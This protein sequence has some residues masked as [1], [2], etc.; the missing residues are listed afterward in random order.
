MS[1]DRAAQLSCGAYAA[2]LIGQRVRRLVSLQADVLADR[3]PEPLHQMRVCCRQLR[4]TLEQFDAALL[5][6]EQVTPRRVAKVGHQ[7]GLTRDLDVLRERIEQQ[8]LPGLPAGELQLLQRFFKAL[9]RERRHAF[10]A[11]E[12]TIKGRRYLK[13]LSRLQ[14]WLRQPQFTPMGVQPVIDWL[15]DLA[16]VAVQELTL[17][18]GWHV[19]DLEAA[20]AAEALHEL[21]RRIKRARYG[22]RNLCDLES[23]FQPWCDQFKRMQG[24]LGD[25]NDLQLLEQALDHHL[26][27]DLDTQLPVLRSRLLECRQQAWQRWQVAAAELK[28]PAGRRQLQQLLS[29]LLTNP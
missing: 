17:Q 7:L 19:D 22:L 9:R 16:Q 8:L 10:D 28:Q 24:D 1:D 3:D 25:L 20:G 26:D 29:G 21:R 13:L 6:P 27:L 11:L 18:P 12:Q 5:L 4:S 23:R 2:D 15:P 14:G